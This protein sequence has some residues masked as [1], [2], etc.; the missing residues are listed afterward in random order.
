MPPPRRP[1]ERRTPLTSSTPLARTIPMR[2]GSELRRGVTP[3][4]G[5]PLQ[6]GTASVRSTPEWLA[7]SAERRFC[8]AVKEGAVPEAR[9]D[10]GPCLIYTGGKSD[11]GYG[12]F[13]YNERNG[14][15]HRYA[16]E[17]VNGPIP[18][19]LTI[20]HLCRVRACV[21]V[22]HL[23]VV[24]AITNYQR[25]VSAWVECAKGHP[26][27][28]DNKAKDERLRCGTCEAEG[29]RRGQEKRRK[30]KPGEPHPN[31]RYDQD[32]VRDAIARILAGSLSISNAARDIGCSAKYLGRRAWEAAK[33]ATFKRDGNT[34]ANCGKRAKDAQ[35][36]I[37]RGMGGSRDPRIAY[38][39][40]NLVSLCRD[41]HELAE[42]RDEQ[43]H[44]KGFWLSSGENP[45]AVPVTYATPDGPEKRYLTE[46]G[47][48]SDKPPAVGAA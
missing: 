38:G 19:G 41:C 25:A 4:P 16:W 22:E 18:S 13:R 2:D 40:V 11:N 39:L 35:H 20:D 6:R 14:Y 26:Y 1:L 44:A 10:L 36:R 43:M 31:V 23:E 28:E 3:L 21:R 15:A 9:P 32:A 47:G 27:T 24:D 48:Y 46:D 37:A 34:C 42:S 29:R 33:R 8:R 5:A 45:A 17:R 30:L 12:Q 7:A